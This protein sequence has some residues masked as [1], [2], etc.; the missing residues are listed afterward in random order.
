MGKKIVYFISN[1]D[2]TGIELALEN[3]EDKLTLCLIQNAVYSGNK[4]E[5]IISTALDQGINIIACKNDVEIR[6]LNK[7]IYEQIKLLDYGE[8]I[9]EVLTNDSIINI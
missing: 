1:E 8:I 7:Y 4:K 3:K 6:G 9:D 2:K 5:I